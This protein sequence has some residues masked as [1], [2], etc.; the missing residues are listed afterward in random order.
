MCYYCLCARFHATNASYDV[1][2]GDGDDTD[3]EVTTAVSN[4]ATLL[5]RSGDSAVARSSCA[6]T[7][8]TA[9]D[10]A[11]LSHS[12]TTSVCVCVCVCVCVY[13]NGALKN[14]GE[15]SRTSI[16]IERAVGPNPALVNDH[17]KER[18]IGVAGA[19]LDDHR[20]PHI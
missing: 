17:S 11:C 4:G 16:E 19:T 10:S 20:T 14:E 8:G 2:D 13:V 6:F 12:S 7:R 5:F 18:N 1:S 9:L 15:S 3:D